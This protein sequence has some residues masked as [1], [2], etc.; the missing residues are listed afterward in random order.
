[1]LG[2]TVEQT[3]HSLPPPGSHGSAVLERR[4]MIAQPGSAI[5]LQP[6]DAEACLREGV[7]PH[8]LYNREEAEFR[9][10]GVDAAIA[11]MVGTMNVL[12]PIS[13]R[14]SAPL[15]NSGAAVAIP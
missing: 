5:V 13:D 12:T 11:R 8:D 2:R 1:M 6:L 10:H 9:E 7:D 14:H 4:G 15:C 3:Y